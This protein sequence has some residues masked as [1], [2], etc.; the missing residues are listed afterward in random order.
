MNT[1]KYLDDWAEDQGFIKLSNDRYLDC[2]DH[3]WPR[4]WLVDYLKEILG[5]EVE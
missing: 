3:V 1:S 2:D 5:V 4:E